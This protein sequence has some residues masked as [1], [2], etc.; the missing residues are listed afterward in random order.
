MAAI[1]IAS[2]RGVSG[3]QFSDFTVGTSAPGSGDFELRYN[4]TDTNSV[5]VTR[6]DLELFLRAVERFLLQAGLNPRRALRATV[7]T[8]VVTGASH[9]ALASRTSR[10]AGGPGAVLSATCGGTVLG[11]SG[12]DLRRYSGHHPTEPGDAF[13]LRRSER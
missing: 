13:D 10:S 5:N 7:S 1:S 4:T 11:H 2:S 3:F 12:H 8:T 6:K 9:E